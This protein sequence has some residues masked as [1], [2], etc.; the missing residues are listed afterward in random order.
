[1]K[2]PL[3][4]LTADHAALRADLDAA[5][6]AVIDSGRFIGG[7][8]VSGLEAEVA[9][10]CQTGHC[11][12]VSSGTDALLI[13]LM[14]LDIGPGDEVVTTPF[15]FFATAGVIARL[16]ATPVFAD[17]EPDSFNLDPTA[18]ASACSD[19]TR[20][21]MPVHL[22]GRRARHPDV[23]DI[24]VIEDAAQAIGTGAVR[25]LAAGLSFF[26]T[27]NLGAFG[28][29]GAVLSD[30]EAFAERVRLLRN[31]GAKPKYYHALV[32]GNFR[33]DA[34]Q[35][36]ILRV[37]LGQLEA[38][39]AA[40][41][42]NAE[43]YRALFAAAN[44]PAELVVPSDSPEHIYN[45][46]VV[47]APRRDQLRAHLREADI[48]TEIYYPRPFHLQ[49]C[50]AH[51]GYGQGAFPHAEAAAN[52]VLALPV[53]PALSEDQQAYVVDTIAAFY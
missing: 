14:A 25:G 43:R 22:Y 28:D 2:I 24:A 51:L 17:I 16:G 15:S 45:Q 47:R 13:M 39:T 1:M 36:A 5:I 31:H 6:A 20:A 53:Y 12:G 9:A 35:A 18:A 42:R 40:R 26:P 27:K 8:Q 41:R 32:G 49:E 34:I 46:F 50:F 7:P 44:V 23:G 48:A 11:V 21:V 38:W 4:D 37:K 30:D 3:V 19:R 29:A 33:L 10:V 52:E